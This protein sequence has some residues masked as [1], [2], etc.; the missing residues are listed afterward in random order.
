MG[1][2]SQALQGQ[3]VYLDA[4]V[5]IYGLE[6]VAPWTAPLHDVFVGM[7]AGQIQASTSALTLV[8]C[9]VRPF[10]L[11][12]DDLVQ[13]YRMVL[14]AR[15]GLEIAP[16]HTEVLISAARLRAQLGLKL[17]DA[18]HAATAQAT[19]CTALLTNDTGFRRLP[20]VQL[21]LLSD[22]AQA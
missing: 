21:F 22:W 17:P 8:E 1:A 10:A 6:G 20:G 14:S 9:L 4:N 19:G 16:V 18:I 2:L 3:R 12:R 7:E 5:F 15:P 13:L 11:A